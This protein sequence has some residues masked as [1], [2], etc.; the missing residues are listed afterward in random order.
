MPVKIARRLLVLLGMSESPVLGE[1][2]RRC[3]QF[4]ISMPGNLQL[5]SAA[6]DSNYEAII[7]M[8]DKVKSE[9]NS[10]AWLKEN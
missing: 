10:S 9:V 2:I 1:I 5:V 7:Q 4:Q 8:L 3:N 6:S